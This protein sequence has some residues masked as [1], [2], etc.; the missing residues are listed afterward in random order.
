MDE[1][2]AE[3]SASYLGVEDGGRKKLMKAHTLRRATARHLGAL[4]WLRCSVGA[5]VNLGGWMERTDGRC[6]NAFT[7]PSEVPKC[8]SIWLLSI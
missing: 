3:P 7:V 6:G 2:L 4:V 5:A 8:F 1:N